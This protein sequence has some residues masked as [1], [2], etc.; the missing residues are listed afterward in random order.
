MKTYEQ[1][2]LKSGKRLWHVHAY[3][4]T[5][6][7]TGQPKYFDRRSFATKADA[8]HALNAAKADFQRGLDISAGDQSLTLAEVYAE[9]KP[10]YEERVRESTTLNSRRTWKNIIL[11]KF[12]S[13]HIDAI[14][15]RAL[16]SWLFELAKKY[17]SLQVI[18]AQT[19][20][21]L[22]YAV[23]M[24][25]IDHNPMDA[26]ELPHN[27]ASS[28]RIAKN[29]FELDELE[30]F[31]NTAYKLTV[32]DIASARCIVALLLIAATGMRI[33][34]ACAL[35]WSGVDLT[36]GTAKIAHGT[37]QTGHGVKIGPTKTVAS[38]RQV[39]FGGLALDALRK[40]RDWQR[41]QSA[42]IN[43]NGLVFASPF[44]MTEITPKSTIRNQM[45]K[46]CELAGV[47]RITTHGL[48]HTKATLLNQVGV[49]PADI[50]AVLGHTNTQFT[51]QTYVH[52]TR[53]GMD[54]ANDKFQQLINL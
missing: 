22:R 10:M 39:S 18:K 24:E 5:D 45:T 26:V 46:L 13:W 19:N 8:V 27:C 25:Y 52:P 44:A 41:K 36:S 35:S 7:R 31:V 23:R 4:G 32:D 51:M 37:V 12:G 43:I 3:L 9:W 6:A 49:D 47:R 15:P 34:E 2:K 50:S 28:N 14:S 29:Y 33:G 17:A 53:K 20:M 21:V 42:V 38:V 40:W 30:Q 54:E 11:P 1:Y 16:Q 48:R